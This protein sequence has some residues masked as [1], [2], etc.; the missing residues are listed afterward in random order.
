MDVAR[1]Q[2]LLAWVD[3]RGT[4]AEIARKRDAAPRCLGGEHHVYFDEGEHSWAF[5]CP[6]SLSPDER[7]RVFTDDPPGREQFDKYREFARLQRRSRKLV[8]PPSEELE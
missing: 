3:E 7:L 4:C 1:W 5:R 8:R 6:E 2:P